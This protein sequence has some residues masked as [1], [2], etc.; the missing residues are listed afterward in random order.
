[1]FTSRTGFEMYQK[2]RPIAELLL[3]YRC[4]ALSVVYHHSLDMTSPSFHGRVPVLLCV[5]YKCATR[6]VQRS[7]MVR[8]LVSQPCRRIGG[9]VL[10]P[11]LLSGENMDLHALTPASEERNKSAILV[12]AVIALHGMQWLE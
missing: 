12:N 6:A 9:R 8:W 1:M 11:R 3:F 2:L 7:R 4:C 10:H 5:L